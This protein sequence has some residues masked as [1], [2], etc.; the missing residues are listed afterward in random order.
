MHGEYFY[1]LPFHF[2]YLYKFYEG[3]NDVKSNN[4]LILINNPRIW[5]NVKSIELNRYNSY[6]RNFIKELKIKMPKLNLI[7]FGRYSDFPTNYSPAMNDEREKLDLRLDNVTIIQILTGSMEDK[8][9]WIISSLPN[10]RHLILSSEYLSSI[11]YK[12]VPIL[13]ER[14]QRLDIYVNSQFNKQLR[15]IS[16]VYFSNVQHINIRL[17]YPSNEL[18]FY[19]EIMKILK[20][21]KNLKTLLI[22]ID[23]SDFSPDTVEIMKLIEYLDMNGIMKNY[24]VKHFKAYCL[25]SRGEFIDSGVADGVLLSLRKSSFFSGLIRFFSRKK[26]IVECKRNFN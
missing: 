15:K 12:L 6:D 1:T 4:P 16:Y 14:I 19:A 11:D 26:N 9:D 20:N 25:F 10:L 2:D 3:F 13:N 21:F 18:S 5:F 8:K 17:N 22:C 23:G 7:K 24:Q